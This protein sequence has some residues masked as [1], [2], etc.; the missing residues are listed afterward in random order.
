MSTMTSRRPR[1]PRLPEAPQEWTRRK[2]QA[3]AALAALVALALLGGA[4]FS[5]AAIVTDDAPGH[6]STPAH[7]SSGG[8]DQDRL[9]AAE[10]PTASLEAAQPGPLSTRTTETLTLPGATDVGP[11]GVP[12]G[13]PRTPEGA[14]AQLAAIDRAA[15]EPASV[16]QAQEVISHWA[17][18]GGPTPESW[19]G[20]QAVASLLSAAELPATGSPD[21]SL[22]VIPAMGFIKGSVGEAFVV[23]C[24]DFVLVA[25][26]VEVNR[27]AAADCQ[28]MV[29]TQGR[30]MI[31]PGAE[32]A[33][34]PSLWPGTQASFDAGYQWL[35][36]T[37]P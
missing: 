37:G 17:L 2:L 21:L 12:T 18:P 24:I 8:S 5:V 28:R 30:W 22:Q 10:L 25:S 33:P 34:A 13:F 1:P 9:A 29:W 11:A 3:L 14:L 26:T 35:K 32:P 27:I 15:I 16:S 20:V 19:S 4:V 23:P 31:G 36:V 6:H 7:E